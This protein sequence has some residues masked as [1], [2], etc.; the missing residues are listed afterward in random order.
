MRADKRRKAQLAAKARSFGLMLIEMASLGARRLGDAV[1][2]FRALGETQPNQES[3]PLPRHAARRSRRRRCR[4][5]R[6]ARRG[7]RPVTSARRRLH[8]FRA[9][10]KTS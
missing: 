9:Y 5:L 7:D 4:T 8:T 1:A 10:G 3:R 2:L 6:R